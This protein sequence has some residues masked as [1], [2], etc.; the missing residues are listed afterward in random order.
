MIASS[1]VRN[2]PNK[3]E[4]IAHEWFARFVF[5]VRSTHKQEA[6]IK[7][8]NYYFFAIALF[9]LDFILLLQKKHLLLHSQ[10]RRKLLVRRM[11]R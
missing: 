1:L 10:T 7:N 3:N 9:F 11:A 4:R 5:S 6:S 2:T 8:Q